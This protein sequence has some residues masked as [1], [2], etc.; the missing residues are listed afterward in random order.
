MSVIYGWEKFFNALNYAVVSEDSL[1]HRLEV[2]LC[3]V[4]HLQRDDFP[5]DESWDTFRKM[6]DE[7]TKRPAR[8]EGEG[9]IRATTAQ[10]TNEEASKWLLEAVSLFSDL[11]EASGKEA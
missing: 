9:T 10:M 8:T 11:A 5:D 3:G 2:V 6:L 4:N 7:G 1:Q